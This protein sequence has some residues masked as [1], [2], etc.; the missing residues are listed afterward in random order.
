MRI[1]IAMALPSSANLREYWAARAKRARAQRWTVRCHLAAQRWSV[2]EHAVAH[3]R[4]QHLLRIRLTRI[5][6]RVLDTDN[7]AASLKACRDGVA[8]WL[9]IDDGDE[10]LLWEYAQERAPIPY[11]QAVRVEMW[12]VVP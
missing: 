11:Y 7:L 1:E 4:A 12:E 5:A 6:P 10:H 3:V 2:Q 8:D 9:G